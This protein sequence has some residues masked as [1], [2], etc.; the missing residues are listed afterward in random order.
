MMNEGQPHDP[1]GKIVNGKC[2]AECCEG[3]EE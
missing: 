2:N 3:S 1:Q